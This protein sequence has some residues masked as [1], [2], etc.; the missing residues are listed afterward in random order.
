MKIV[1]KCATEI[2]G[3][4]VPMT[5]IGGKGKEAHAQ[6][7]CLDAPEKE[8]RAAINRQHAVLAPAKSKVNFNLKKPAPAT[9]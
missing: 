6:P 8:A 3:Q 7:T 9:K 4:M 1:L 2:A 5:S